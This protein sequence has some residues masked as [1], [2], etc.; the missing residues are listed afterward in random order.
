M[1]RHKAEDIVARALDVGRDELGVDL[2]TLLDVRDI[3]TRHAGLF[4]LL[5]LVRAEIGRGGI[6]IELAEAMTTGHDIVQYLVGL[7]DEQ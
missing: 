7:P 1:K 3:P 4:Q 6:T 5:V 2:R